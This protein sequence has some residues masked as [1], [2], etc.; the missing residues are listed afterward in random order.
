MPTESGKGGEPAVVDNLVGGTSPF[1]L[2]GTIQHMGGS[3]ST[4]PIYCGFQL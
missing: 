4:T 1:T 3:L 2:K